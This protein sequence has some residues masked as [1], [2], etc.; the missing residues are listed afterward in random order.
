MALLASWLLAAVL[1]CA[2]ADSGKPRVARR[3]PLQAPTRPP[4]SHPRNPLNNPQHLAS[5]ATALN[6]PP[7]SNAP[8]YVA[9]AVQMSCVG[10]YD[11]APSDNIADTLTAMEQ[12]VAEAARSHAQIIT[13]PE[14]ILCW[15]ALGGTRLSLRVYGET[16]PTVPSVASLGLDKS[17]VPCGDV[18]FHA[19]PQLQR[20]SCAALKYNIT[21]VFNI[22]DVQP[23]DATNDDINCP[24]D[25]AFQYDTAVAFRSD[26]ALVAKYHK[27]HLFSGGTQ[28]NVPPKDQLPV[29]FDTP[30]GVRFGLV[31]CFDIEFGSPFWQLWALGIRDFPLPTFW[32]NTP[33]TYTATMV[34]QAKSRVWGIN[35][36]A[37]NVG[38]CGSIP[39]SASAGGGIYSRGQLLNVS[40]EPS[41]PTVNQVLVAAV[42]ALATLAPTSTQPTRPASANESLCFASPPSPPAPPLSSKSQQPF[43]CRLPF[44]DAMCV[45]LSASFATDPDGSTA[46]VTS[47]GVQC[48]ALYTVANNGT[49]TNSTTTEYVL[50][51]V[52][53][54]VHE[55][56]SGTLALQL[57]MVARCSTTQNDGPDGNNDQVVCAPTWTGTLAFQRLT[58][59]GRFASSHEVLPMLAVG[60]AQLVEPE[61][62]AV[63]RNACNTTATFWQ[64]QPSAESMEPLFSLGLLAFPRNNEAR[65]R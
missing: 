26:G 25:G 51:A 53:S 30:F 63:T 38:G 54:S 11:T 37:A 22:V 36:M 28:F 16:V 42:P 49:L 46:T 55:P 8:G 44:M 34:Q 10:A 31:V 5:H 24:P 12:R 60:S 2:S 4:A 21:V 15:P 52:N 35:L 3:V 1:L 23:C 27:A 56:A 32:S 29:Y 7:S 57:C 19:R 58:V 59:S 40:F 48:D 20:M 17:I 33:P 18:S 9:A 45:R 6:M 14:D 61:R 50:A 65:T 47:D 64:E 39:A 13:F 43:A 62:L 41:V